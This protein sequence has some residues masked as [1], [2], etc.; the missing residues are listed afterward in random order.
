MPETPILELRD[1]SPA[2]SPTPISASVT[3]PEAASA[4]DHGV[5]ASERPI[6]PR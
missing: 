3:E 2:G 5:P 6:A 1:Q 4:F